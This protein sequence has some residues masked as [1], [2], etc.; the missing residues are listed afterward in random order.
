MLMN[1]NPQYLAQENTDPAF[2]QAGE[3]LDELNTVMGTLRAARQKELALTKEIDSLIETLATK[4]AE[5]EN[6]SRE[7]ISAQETWVT[8]VKELVELKI[9]HDCLSSKSK[10]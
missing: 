10:V 5:Q 6:L 1:F 7:L 3:L 4:Q 2:T 8:L 9:N